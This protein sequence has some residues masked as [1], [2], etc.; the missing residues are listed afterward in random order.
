MSRLP[1]VS[2]RRAIKVFTSIGYVIVRQKGSHMRLRDDVNPSHLPLTVPDH[3]V[4]RPGLLRDLLRDAD[5]SV[6][7]F[8]RLLKE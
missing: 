2:G 6:E 1:V 5:L 4:L 8:V 7:D 3:K